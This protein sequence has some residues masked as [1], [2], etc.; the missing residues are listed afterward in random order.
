MLGISHLHTSISR[1][2]MSTIIHHT[3]ILFRSNINYYNANA[4]GVSQLAGPV[5]PFRHSKI[6]GVFTEEILHAGC[7]KYGMSISQEDNQ[8]LISD[9]RW[10]SSAMDHT[11]VNFWSST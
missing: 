5:Q 1:R 11:S 9:N 8:D 2:Y 7:L 4:K 6:S 3:S 10:Q